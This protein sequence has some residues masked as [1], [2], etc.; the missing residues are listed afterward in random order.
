MARENTTFKI[1]DV[2]RR[3]ESAMQ[4]V[5]AIDWFNVCK[6]CEAIEE[7]FWTSDGLQDE[8]GI[9]LGLDSSDSDTSDQEK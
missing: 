8:V 7:K 1:A 2:K 3:M 5:I 4:H 6:H 9:H